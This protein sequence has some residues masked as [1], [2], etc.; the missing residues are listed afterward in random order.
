MD[1]I[2]LLHKDADSDFGV[3]FPDFPGCV[4]AGSTLDEARR[5]AAEALAG[6]IE[7][8][9]E[10]GDAM[11]APST[12]DDLARDPEVLKDAIAFLVSVAPPARSVRINITLREDQ[13]SDIDAAAR[14]AGLS[15]SA[16]LAVA[17]Q[18]WGKG[19]AS[20]HNNLP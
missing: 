19:D 12:L 6:H 10:Y 5:M 15:R 20:G 7:T 17:A 11:P 3:S 13:L 14:R 2:A 9:A 1:Y 16:F 18:A 8:M 4:T